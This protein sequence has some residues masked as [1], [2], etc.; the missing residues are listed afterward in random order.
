VNT[1]SHDVPGLNGQ[2]PEYQGTV[3]D[4][5]YSQRPEYVAGTKRLWS[6]VFAALCLWLLSVLAVF[7]LPALVALPYII[8]R[9]W[10]VPDAAQSLTTDHTV[11]LFTVIG[12]IPAHIVTFF[13][14]W[15]LVTQRGKR[16][17]WRTLGWEY[18]PTFRT[19]WAVGTAIVL[20]IIGAV[21]AKLIGGAPTD[22]DILVNSTLAVRLLLAILATTT[23]PLV[24]E[25]VYRGILYPS[26]EKTLGMPWAVTTVS[27]LFAL[28]HFYQYRKNL[29]VIVVIVML[30]VSLTLIR[31]YTGRLLPCFIIHVVFNGIV[32][33]LIVF[34]PY[35]EQLDKSVGPK[36]GLFSVWRMIRL[37]T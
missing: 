29:G 16:P 13:A 1:P 4:G 5:P 28:V 24:E 18:G 9:Y 11:L 7:I 15:M 14:A 36:T 31:A 2:T 19:W 27:F 35:I 12:V 8:F 3:V 32:S 20:Y 37:V 30:S 26:L 22:I 10:G 17:F 25:I 23:G 33:I 6:D 21:L 34:Q